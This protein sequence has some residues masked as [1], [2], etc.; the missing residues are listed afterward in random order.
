MAQ[1]TIVV[2]KN[3]RLQIDFSGFQ[4]ST[5]Y[6]E[7]TKLAH[8]LAKFGIEEKVENVHAKEEA[9][10]EAKEHVRNES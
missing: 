2:D 3:C 8:I 4:G 7:H 10:A 9:Q 5:C 6:S 1:I